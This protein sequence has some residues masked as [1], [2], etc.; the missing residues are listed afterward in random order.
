M[1]NSSN[2]RA[3][4]RGVGACLF[5]PTLE[6][7]GAPAP[8]LK[9]GK[10]GSATRL[11]YLYFPNGAA[12]GSWAP[13]KVGPDGSLERLNDWMSPLEPHKRDLVVTRNLWTPRGNGHG[14]GTA[15]WLTGGAFDGRRNDVGSASVDQMVAQHLSASPLP[16]LEVSTSGEGSFSGSLSRNCLSWTSRDTPAVRE[17]VPR[18]IFDKL[19][20]RSKEGFVNKSVLDLV[21]SQ[22]KD[23]KRRASRADQ[24]KIDEYFDAV[25]SVEKRLAFAEEQSLR[26]GEDLSLIHI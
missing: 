18:A 25:R 19:F 8:G 13:S 10:A 9:G 6:S 14:A 5:L 11:A 7:M 23:L 4:L 15:T 26:M 2:R 21:L 16:S 3:F 20:R 17:T 1:T 24:R 12:A 22:S